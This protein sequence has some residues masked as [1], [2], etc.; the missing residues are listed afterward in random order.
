VE[1][2]LSHDALELLWPKL[3]LWVTQHP[4]VRDTHKVRVCHV[5]SRCRI[6][7]TA[8]LCF[9][10][11]SLSLYPCFTD[12][13]CNLSPPVPSQSLSLVELG[14]VPSFVLVSAPIAHFLPK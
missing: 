1:Y 3:T 8:R 13:F 7:R 12:F 6:L 10:Y 5:Y 9:T 4:T 14:Q 11:F 2:L